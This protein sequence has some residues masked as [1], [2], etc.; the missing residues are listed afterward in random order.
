MDVQ[1]SVEVEGNYEELVAVIAAAVAI[2]LGLDVPDI[3]IKS[4]RRLSNSTPSWRA[5]GKQEQMLGKL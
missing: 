2:Q 1:Q 5:V 3:N 4:I